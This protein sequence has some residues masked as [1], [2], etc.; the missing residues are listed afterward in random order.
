MISSSLK[1]IFS[2]D[3]MEKRYKVISKWTLRLIFSLALLGWLLAR[4]DLSVIWTVASRLPI[5]MIPVLIA[6]HLLAIVV[7]ALRWRLL[8]PQHNFSLLFRLNLVGQF[9]SLVVPGQLAGDVVKAYRLGK[10]YQDAEIVAASVLLDKVTGLISLLLLG[11]VGLYLSKLQVHSTILITVSL[12]LFTILIILALGHMKSFVRVLQAIYGYLESRFYKPRRLIGQL[13]FF[14]DA[15][16][17]YMNRP[18]LLIG[19]VVMGFGYQ[20]VSLLI[21]LLISSRIGIS[22]GLEEWL[23]V[24]A[25][26]SVAVLIPLTVGGIGIREGAFVLVLGLLGV[27]SESALAISLTIFGLQVIVASLGAFFEVIG[28]KRKS[29]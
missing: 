14:T 8:I 28:V 12:A 15:W 16:L 26:V 25:I 20:F 3:K 9:Y 7:G 29:V 1:D 24:F 10:G 23:W 5:G 18:W 6:L 4:T 11:L 19:S 17:S 13:R 2:T 22:I 27:P 21:I